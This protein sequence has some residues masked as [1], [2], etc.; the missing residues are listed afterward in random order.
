VETT[1]VKGLQV[2]EAIASSNRPRGVSDLGRELGMT[3]SNTHR[4]LQTLSARGYVRHDPE[5]GL[6]ESTLRLFELGSAVAMR[7]DVRTV[8][9][10]IMQTLARKVDEN[11]ILSVRDGHEVL[12]LD[13]VEGTRT[14]RTYTP[15]GAR[16]PMHSTSPGKLLLAYATA[17]VI[18]V[19]AR[20][21]TK[22]SPRTIANRPRLNAELARIRTQGYAIASS[23][24]HEDVAGVSAPVRRGDGTIVAALTVSGPV[25][26][27]KPALIKAYLPHVLS[28]AHEISERLGYRARD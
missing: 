1:L 21:L 11:T 22:F 13:R 5:R 4:L 17:D 25:V 12:V 16:S 6:Y 26:R 19:V 2:L 23:E 8:A 14:L 28:A 7:L 24:W 18:D 20:A 10:P 27:F 15:L 3:R 9:H